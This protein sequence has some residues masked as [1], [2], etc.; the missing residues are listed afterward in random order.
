VDEQMNTSEPKKILLIRMLGL[1]DTLSIGL[2]ALRYYQH[3]YPDAEL[4]FLTIAEAAE[5]IAIAEPQ[6][7]TH[8][9]AKEQ[10]PDDFLAA[11]EVFLGL[12][13]DI[14]GEAYEQI[15]NLD[16]AFMPCFLAR[17]LKDAGETVRGN[18]LSR[19]VQHLLEQFQDQSLQ[20]DYVNLP[21]QYMDS[22]YFTMARWHTRWWEGS[23][24]PDGGYPEY[25]LRSCC[26]YSDLEM[27]MSI[28]VNA[29]AKLRKQGA[30]KKVIAL[31][32]AQADDAY[33]YPH[34]KQLQ[35][36][37]EKKGYMVW[38]DADKHYSV[39]QKLKRLKA[40]D[41]MVTKAGANQWFA[42]AVGCPSLLITASS[43]P[44][45]LMPD[46]AT[47][48]TQPCP[49]HSPQSQLSFAKKCLCDDPEDL[50]EGIASIF[51][52]LEEELRNE[53]EGP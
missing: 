42:T 29:D 36:A 6:V 44:K 46:Y 52:Q 24:L 40:S 49:I 30:D 7:K 13:E 12:A 25:Y 37:L 32:L 38:S 53:A 50:V 21:E 5:I 11:M 26:G 33:P 17:F 15:I 1:G 47:E 22:T 19:S 18:L 8:S 23:F 28:K 3:L 16:T 48:Q 4:H 31:C 20:A 43:E 9:L 51:E 35:S 39:E 14:I 2:P 27:K 34:A 45:T 10:W 41:L